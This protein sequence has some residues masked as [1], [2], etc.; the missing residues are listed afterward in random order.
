MENY[1][2]VTLLNSIYARSKVYAMVVERRLKKEMEEREMLPDGQ[3]EFRRGRG[4][5]NNIYVLNCVVNRELQ[6]EGG[7]VYAFFVDLRT[8][9]V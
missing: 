8:S 4:T 6:Q 1:R 5:I 2:S 3:V 7:G 9:D